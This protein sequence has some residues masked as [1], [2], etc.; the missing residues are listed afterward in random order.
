MVTFFNFNG[1]LCCIL[2]LFLKFLHR[3]GQSQSQSSRLNCRRRWKSWSCGSRWLL[4]ITRRSTESASGCADRSPN[5]HRSRK[6]SRR[7]VRACVCSHAC[8]LVYTNG[9]NIF[10]IASFTPTRHIMIQPIQDS[11][12]DTG[13][14]IKFSHDIFEEEKNQRKINYQTMN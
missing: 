7:C 2:H 10:N 12:H 9:N 14:M 8:V 4:S 5:L 6:C 1:S 13:F 11:I 3:R